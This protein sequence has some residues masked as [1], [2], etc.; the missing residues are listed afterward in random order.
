M[1]PS[2]RKRLCVVLC[3]DQVIILGLGRGL[4]PRVILQ[5]I[6]PCAQVADAPGWQPALDVFEHWLGSHEMDSAAVTVILSGHFVR[7]ALM[8]YSAEVTSRAEERAL[9]Q[10]LFEGIY[11]ERAR[12]WTLEIGQSGYGE[13]RLIAAA[14]TL[15]LE[16]ITATLAPTTLKL[17]AI[18][19]YFVQAFN[20]FRAQI[21]AAD[22]L[23][24]VVESD[25]LT[26]VTFRGG[27]LVGVRHVPLSDETDEQL[28]RLLHREAL[29]GGFDP[30]GLAVYLHVVGR[31][32]FSLSGADGM[33]V[34]A[35]RAVDK[36]GV[37][38]VE[39]AGFEM[40]GIGLYA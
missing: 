36:H 30:E 29:T 27:Q 28:S 15:L 11:G 9:A 4:R 26:G 40:A 12:Q 14:D 33:K 6:L 23:F 39:E 22:G 3:P 38:F 32:D 13:T 20:C 24:A 21:Q 37:P 19:P 35:L 5:T 25:R 34:H 1:L 7:Y 17:R 10:I 2:W 18:A 31:P 16:R 8:P